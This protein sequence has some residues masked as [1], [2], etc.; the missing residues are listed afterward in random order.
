MGVC[1]IAEFDLEF[2]PVDYMVVES[3]GPVTVC[4][5]QTSFPE[6]SFE[7]DVDVLFF[8]R[9]DTADCE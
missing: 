9:D 2:D 4:V 5:T 8:T 7:R 6:V 1:F 3:A